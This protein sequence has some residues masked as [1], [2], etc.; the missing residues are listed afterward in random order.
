M[1]GICLQEVNYTHTNVDASS[2]AFVWQ[3]HK[4]VC[5]AAASNWLLL[6]SAAIYLCKRTMQNKA[7]LELADYEAVS[8]LFTLLEPSSVHYL[9]TTD[10]LNQA[11]I[12]TTTAS[13]R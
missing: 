13:L 4:K 7:R 2:V 11:N 5:Q 10:L 6:S 8:A 1:G 12:Y 3:R 9:Y